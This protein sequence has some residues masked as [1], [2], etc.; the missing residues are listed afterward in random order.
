MT[1]EV[2]SSTSVKDDGGIRIDYDQRVDEEGDEDAG[3]VAVKIILVG[4]SAVGKSK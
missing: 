1:E 3:G 2:S 4:D